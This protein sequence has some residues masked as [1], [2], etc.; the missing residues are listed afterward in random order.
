MSPISYQSLNGANSGSRG[1][2]EEVKKKENHPNLTPEMMGKS[3]QVHLIMFG[4]SRA[5]K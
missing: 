4:N 1:P 3:N 2:R 5:L